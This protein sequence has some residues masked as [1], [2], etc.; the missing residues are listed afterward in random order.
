M[1]CPEG[2]LLPQGGTAAALDRRPIWLFPLVY[3]AWARARAEHIGQWI[4]QVGGSLARGVLD[5]AFGLAAR[6]DDVGFMGMALDWSRAYDRV[7]H[8][9]L[10]MVLEGGAAAPRARSAPFE[11]LRRPSSHQG[12]WHPG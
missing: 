10:R 2:L 3:R 4:R 5:A 9:S 11:C 1:A 6:G 8:A 7:N 12:W